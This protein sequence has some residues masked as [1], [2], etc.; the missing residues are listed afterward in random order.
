MVK[1]QDFDLVLLDLMMPEMSGTDV[2]RRIRMLCPALPVVIITGFPD[3]KIFEEL[4]GSGVK[5]FLIKPDDFNKS[6]IEE[7]CKMFNIKELRSTQAYR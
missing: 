3:E 7:L 6:K 5:T 4:R 1:S 2:Y